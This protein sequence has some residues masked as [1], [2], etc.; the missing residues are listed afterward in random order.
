M[1]KN[2]S[3]RIAIVVIA[4]TLIT[5]CFVGSTFA[6]YTATVTGSDTTSRVAKFVVTAFGATASST[7]DS[8]TFDLFAVSAVYDTKNADFDGDGVVDQDIKTATD[9]NAIIAPGS[10]GKL[11]FDAVNTSEVTVNYGVEFS[12]VEADVPLKW[13]LDG[14]TWEDDIAELNIPASESTVLTMTGAT[15]TDT[16]TVFWQWAI[17]EAGNDDTTLGFAGTAAPSV[18]IAVTFEQ[19]D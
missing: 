17:D 19:V 14:S 11:S 7:V 5:S 13:S 15:N 10:W 1:K 18:S 9:T 6:K 12:A 8:A 3:M 16:I 2:N 4:L